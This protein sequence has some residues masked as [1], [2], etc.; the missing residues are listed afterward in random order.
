MVVRDYSLLTSKTVPRN[1]DAKCG[2][3]TP[4]VWP[5]CKVCSLVKENFMSVL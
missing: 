3:V 2:P 4:V 1:L 5:A